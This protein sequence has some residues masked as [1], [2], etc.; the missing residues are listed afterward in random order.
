EEK[1]SGRK[2][3]KLLKELGQDSKKKRKLAIYDGK[4]GPYIK[5]GTKNVSLPEE[6]QS[7]EAIENLTLEEAIKIVA[8]AGK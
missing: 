5:A 8:A 3:S 4:Y 1:K 6:K 2:R 7:Q